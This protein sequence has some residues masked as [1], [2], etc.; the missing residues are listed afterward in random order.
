MTSALSFEHADPSVRPQDDLFRYMNGTWLA[1][2]T[3]APDK[4]SAGGFT[5][6][7][8]Q[9]DDHQRGMLACGRLIK[10]ATCLQLCDQT[11][12]FTTEGISPGQTA[13]AA[14]NH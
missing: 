11:G 3:I 7:H 8:D 9:A 6:L 1:T 5:D 4:S 12:P 13:V 14:D 10:V 2:A